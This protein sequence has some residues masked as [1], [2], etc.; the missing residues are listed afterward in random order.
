MLLRERLMKFIYLL[1][2][3]KADEDPRNVSSNIHIFQKKKKATQNP[4]VRNT[5]T[6]SRGICRMIE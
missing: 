5:I 2:G 3:R 1:S 4:I 6:F